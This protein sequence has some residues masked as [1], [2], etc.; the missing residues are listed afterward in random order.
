MLNDRKMLVN[1]AIFNLHCVASQSKL[2]MWVNPLNYP[3]SELEC[4][5]SHSKLGNLAILPPFS[6]CIFRNT[7]IDIDSCTEQQPHIG[8]TGPFYTFQWGKLG[9]LAIPNVGN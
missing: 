7:P 3:H 9:G 5:A 2:K 6:K 1:D 4:E 8:E